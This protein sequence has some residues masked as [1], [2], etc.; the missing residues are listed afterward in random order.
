[1]LSNF[2]QINNFTWVCDGVLSDHDCSLLIEEATPKL[3]EAGTLVGNKTE[4]NDARRAFDTSLLKKNYNSEQEIYSIIKKIEELTSDLTDLPIENQ[5]SL[6]IIKYPEDGQ[7]IE[8]YDIFLRSEEYYGEYMEMGGQ[9][10]FTIMFYLNDSFFGGETNF[11]KL[12]DFKINPH[13]GR[14]VF[15]KSMEDGNLIKESKHSGLPVKDGEKWLAVKWIR[16]RRYQP[17]K[18]GHTNKN[19]V[20]FLNESEEAE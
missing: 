12:D 17:K 2:C 14:S 7:Y 6:N 1:M 5:E 4:R 8:H 15:F 3:K 11:P 16:E 13:K 19:P 10:L 18:A 9:R 20:T